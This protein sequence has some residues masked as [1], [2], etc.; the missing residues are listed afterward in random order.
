MLQALNGKMP[1]LHPKLVKSHVIVMPCSM[2]AMCECT[3]DGE[4]V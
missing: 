4:E 3:A 2:I 1:G